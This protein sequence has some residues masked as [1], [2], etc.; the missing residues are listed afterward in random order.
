MP[1]TTLIPPPRFNFGPEHQVDCQWQQQPELE[2]TPCD[3]SKGHLSIR[4]PEGTRLP[5]IG[6]QFTNVLLTLNGQSFLLPELRV[7]QI[8][9]TREG[10][11]IVMSSRD[12]ELTSHRLWEISH[13]LRH[14]ARCQPATLWDEFSLPK[15]PARGLY[16]EEARLERIDF[17]KDQVGVEL[18]AVSQHSFDPANWSATLKH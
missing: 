1:R 13:A 16:T 15:V 14:Q 17:L 12:C 7:R 2:I 4:L 10:P 6:T 5:T 8:H 9:E 3:V 18:A 11:R